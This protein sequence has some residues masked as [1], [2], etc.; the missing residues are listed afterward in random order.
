MHFS[1]PYVVN[2]GRQRVG[3]HMIKRKVDPM[4]NSKKH[5]H[6]I[7]SPSLASGDVVPEQDQVAVEEESPGTDAPIR[8]VPV[9]PEDQPQVGP[10]V[11]LGQTPPELGKQ[12][13]QTEKAVAD[14]AEARR[15][16]EAR[17]KFGPR[18]S[19]YHFD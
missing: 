8:E 19:P 10:E 14:E 11:F 4:R 2:E 5:N 1:A 3:Q 9:T 18:M 12:I 13:E 6:L 15:Q 7:G 16:T 17:Q